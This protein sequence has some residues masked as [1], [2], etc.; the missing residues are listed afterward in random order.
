MPLSTID[1]ADTF[2]FM[3]YRRSPITLVKGDGCRLWDE[4]G[5][6]YIDFVGGIAVCNLGHSS[7]LVTNAVCEQS[8]KLIHVSN[9][10]YTQP[11]T[12][13]AQV[14][15]ENSF[16]ARVFFCNSGAEANE[17]AIKLARRYSRE[18]FGPERH[19]IITMD[20][21]F[22]G[23]T[24]ATLSATGQEKIKKGFDPLL[25]GF[26]YVPFNDL[27]N[28]RSAI[29]GS[30]CAVLLEP[31]QG[32]GGVVLPDPDYLK[33]VR[34]ICREHAVLLILDEVQVGMGRTGRLFAHQHFGITPDIMTLAKA[35]GNGLPIG[36]MLATEEL[37]DAFGPGSHASTFG[38]TP[39]ITAGA[40]AVVKSLLNDGWIENAR[41]MGVYFKTGLTTLQGKYSIIR[42]VRGLGLLLGLELDRDV[43]GSANV[44]M[45][46]G[47]LI[48][49]VQE[50]VLRFVPPLIIGREEI[51]LLI[52][53]LDV[54]FK[55]I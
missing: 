47:F 46:R 35:L 21:S 39:L 34:E 51:D 18:K 41:E 45:E 1:R 28:L 2:M 5:K 42:D 36:A 43:A 22:H 31:I 20:N 19:V 25:Q 48:N 49:C 7:P 4:D 15:I 40:L 55:E 32:E 53:C 11:Q 6:E 33:G 50:R 26:R 13:L 24:M 27:K 30:V 14:L 9:L 8:K 52:N 3:T 16:A 23:R 37:A 29:D 54:V 17:A 38:G 12:E 10:F 44:C